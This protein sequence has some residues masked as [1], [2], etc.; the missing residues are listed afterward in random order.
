[1]L[2]KILII[3]INYINLWYVPW[4]LKIYLLNKIG[5]QIYAK[6][7]FHEL[8]TTEEMFSESGESIIFFFSGVV[9]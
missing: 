3:K 8:K 6:L 1:M 4:S 7:I 9:F 2:K 5:F